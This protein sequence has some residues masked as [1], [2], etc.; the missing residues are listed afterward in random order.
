VI[1]ESAVFAELTAKN[2]VTLPKANV[3]I[4]GGRGPLVLAEAFCVP[5][6][7]PAALWTACRKEQTNPPAK[8]G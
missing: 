8:I 1:I 7:T 5:V 2:Q 3:L 6:L 4:S